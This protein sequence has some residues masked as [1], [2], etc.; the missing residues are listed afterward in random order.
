MQALHI[1]PQEPSKTLKKLE[2]TYQALRD[3]ILQLESNS[4]SFQEDEEKISNYI[5][6]MGRA[7]IS[8]ALS[9]YDIGSEKIRV[10]EQSYRRRNRARRE[11]QTPFGGIWIERQLYVNRKSD[12]NGLSICPLELQAGIIE[13]YWTPL[14]AQQAIWALS[15]LT[16]RETEMMLFRFKGMNPSR[17]SLDRLPKCLFHSK[18]SA[19]SLLR[20]H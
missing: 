12:G 8:E 17:S 10:G 20:D 18:R 2:E 16:P 15:H 14:A 4:N 19:N 5:H 9:R 3:Y 1:V 13:G 11:Y 6:E 7:A